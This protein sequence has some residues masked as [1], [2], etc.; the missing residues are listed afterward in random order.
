[1]YGCYGTITVDLGKLADAGPSSSVVTSPQEPRTSGPSIS[2]HRRLSP[3]SRRHV[4]A[5]VIHAKSYNSTSTSMTRDGMKRATSH[6]HIPEAI[7]AS[8]GRHH[9]RP[10]Q[11]AVSWSSSLVTR[12]KWNHKNLVN[13]VMFVIIIIVLTTELSLVVQTQ[14]RKTHQKHY[15]SFVIVLWG[16]RWFNTL[17][18]VLQASYSIWI[19][20]LAGAWAFG[21]MMERIPSLRLAFT[22][23][24]STRCGKENERA[25]EP[26][27]RSEI[28]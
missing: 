7:R 28:Q 6:I 23:S 14:K 25:K 2:A 27:D 10:K 1:V 26:T 13:D 5:R 8:R 19:L 4:H 9:H 22:A 17:L 21:T 24:W 20:L 16:L 18:L 11:T 12:H 3:S 15:S